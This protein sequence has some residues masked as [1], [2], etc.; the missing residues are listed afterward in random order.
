MSKNK[1]NKTLK[2]NE[3]NLIQNIYK[4]CNNMYHLYLNNTELN[5]QSCVFVVFY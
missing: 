1:T 4:I 2:E 3:Y 5:S